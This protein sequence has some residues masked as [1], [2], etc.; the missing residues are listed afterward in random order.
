MTTDRDL[1]HQALRRYRR[2]TAAHRYGGLNDGYELAKRALEALER[3]VDT[4]QLSLF[5]DAPP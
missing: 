3:L 2:L 4:R 1:V 5:E